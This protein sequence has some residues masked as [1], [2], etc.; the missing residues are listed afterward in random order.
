M[1]IPQRLTVLEA[2]VDARFNYSQVQRKCWL[3]NVFFKRHE[4]VRKNFEMIFALSINI[5]SRRNY[6]S[7]INENSK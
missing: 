7:K 2:G 6:V 4:E 3:F 5:K 1:R